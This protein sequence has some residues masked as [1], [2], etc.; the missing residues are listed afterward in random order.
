MYRVFFNLVLQHIDAERAHALASRALRILRATAAG[1][2]L[3]RWLVGPTD[4]SLEIRALG[5]RFPS[6]VGV[7]AG[8]DKDAT[9]FE[10][11]GALGFAF[12]EVGTITALRQ[13]GNPRPRV[14]RLVRDGAILNRMGFPNPGAQTAAA[15][16]SRR[17]GDTVVGVNIG[18]SKLAALEAAGDDYCASVRELAPFSDYV[19]I[20]VSSPN[21]PGLRE[22]QAVEL[23]RPLVGDVKSE[24]AATGIMV[25][26]LI[27]ISPDLT[28]DQLDAI[29]TLAIEL[30]ID[31][32][33]AVNTTVHRDGLTHSADPT[34]PFEGGG[35]S[36][37]PLRAQAN[38]VLRRLRAI[39]GDRLVLISVGCV[40]SADDAWERIIAGA[41]LVQVYTG[42]VYAGPAIA[43]RIN[44]DLAQ[45]VSAAGHA[46][47]Q[48]LVGTADAL[49]PAEQRGTTECNGTVAS[50]A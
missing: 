29:A 18:K 50:T 48:D 26:I 31:G 42:L 3:V 39:V 32:I 4:S 33:V 15:R 37:R 10:D 34:A 12:V 7:A 49:A 35:V 46:S 20:N 22:M 5:L 47:V 43:K 13:E 24:L 27:K 21:T 40:D 38:E 1:R 25:P 45:M 14:A 23:L 16:L 36:G 8:V 11:L 19:V 41:T 17:T 44:R 9:S 28:E 2:A 30:E 6:P